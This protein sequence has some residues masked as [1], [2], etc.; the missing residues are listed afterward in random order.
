MIFDVRERKDSQVGKPPVWR[1][2][3]GPAKVLI[4][5]SYQQ[6]SGLIDHLVGSIV[7]ANG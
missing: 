3:S 4:S 6:G 2:L 7:R 5:I 1:K